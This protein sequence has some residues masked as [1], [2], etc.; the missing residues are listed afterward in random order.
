MLIYYRL[1]GGLACIALAVYAVIMLMIFKMVPVTLT[2]A[3]IAAFIL[4]LGFAVDA[5]VLIFER[6]KEEI[7]GG[8]A[9]KAAIEAGFNRAWPAIRDS[10]IST[11]I[12]C[13][14]L[15]WFGSK[16][17][18]GASV[19][20]FAMTLGIGVLVSMFTAILV[21]RTFLRTTVFTPVAKKVSL[22]RP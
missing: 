14:I 16:M 19:M 8:K 9:L 15:Y 21:T 13:A 12:T 6:M 18:G 10:N 7:R 2:L 17:F 11:L 20:G 1:S 22:F 5:N 4:S 3:G